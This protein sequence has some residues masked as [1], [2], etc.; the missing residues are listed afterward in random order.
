MKKLIFLFIMPF[1]A[2]GLFAENNGGL[3][4]S[5]ELVLQISSLPEAKLGFTQSFYFPLLQGDN[6]LTEGNNLKLNLTAE[7]SPISVNGIFKAVLTPVAFIE[8]SAGGRLGA[9]WPL[10]L[11][12]GDI[13][14][15]GLNLPAA[16]NVSEYKGSAFDAL[17]WKAFAGGT[18]QF[19]LAAIFPG[20]WNH[21]VFLSYHEINIHGNTSAK[22][23]EGW[24]YENDDGENCNGLN[25]YGN[26]VLGYQMPVFLSMAAILTEMNLNL[27]DTPGRSA[28]GDDLIRWHFSGI[29][30]FTI[31]EK[32]SVALITQFRTRRNFINFDEHKENKP[33]LHYQSRILDTSNPLRVEFYRVAAAVSLKL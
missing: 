22:P 12:G 5:S 33:H 23:G 10:N 29:L 3:T 27:Y 13:Y 2:L 14:G 28:W 18:F 7:A 24:Y 15:T 6:P 1:F 17:L 4:M 19:D 8:L 9:G 31:N 21:V 20:D 26:F 30:N 16:G 11:F 25:Y 32:L